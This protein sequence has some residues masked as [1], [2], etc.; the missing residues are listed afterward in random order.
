MPDE[1]PILFSDEMV[2]AILE[3]RKGETRRVGPGAHRWLKRR[4]GDVLWVREAWAWHG[5]GHWRDWIEKV[6]EAAR[7]FG[8]RASHPA[9]EALRWK[10]SIHMPR[11][12]CR[13]RVRLT[14]DPRLER[15][16]DMTAKDA[17]A[18]GLERDRRCPEG[19]GWVGADGA[20]H[21]DPWPAYRSLWDHINA[22]RGYP[23]EDNPTVVVLTF[24]P[25]GG[26]GP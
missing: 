6:P 3:D 15:L 13:L 7:D 1:W 4:A 2:R 25:V 19:T 23:W 24:R 16:H 8:H 12:A 11:A 14:E 20:R 22:R 9:P 5:P 17:I 10:P 21:A 18:E 26:D